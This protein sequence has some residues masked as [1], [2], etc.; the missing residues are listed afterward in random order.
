MKIDN[1]I[2]TIN[3]HHI[4]AET[5]FITEG[6]PPLRGKTMQEKMKYMRENYDHIRKAIMRAPRG[7]RDLFGGVIT[8]PVSDNAH[9]GVFYMG[10]ITDSTYYPMC[11]GGIVALA[12]ML[13]NTGKVTPHEPVTEVVIDTALG[14]VNCKAKV[15]DGKAIEVTFTNVPAFIYTKGLEID[16]NDFGRIKV[17]IGY[18]GGSF[19]VFV[20]M[21]K[22]DFDL[23]RERI[24]DMIDPAIK[25][26]E[27]VNNKIE[28]IHPE[29]DDINRLDS[30]M[31]C[32]YD[33]DKGREL[34]VLGDGLIGRCPSGTGTSARM[35]RE[36]D[37]NKLKM[38][39]E[40]VQKCMIDTSLKGKLV[41]K[42]QVGNIDAYI[43]KITSS[44][45]LT[46]IHEFFIEEDDPLK[47]GYVL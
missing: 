24:N 13:I 22:I 30:C 39:E 1:V 8:E 4:G 29:N 46:G 27:K 45:Y 9:C 43:S 12:T 19:C 42:T 44:A 6:V 16:T 7:S 38:G 14:Q 18:G 5:C 41:K 34:L 31:Y 17:D 10:A 23:K 28:C 37:N 35:I 26:I 15:K 2:R 40:F 25:I 32:D 47:E 20:D 36:Y 3:Y 21:G 33:G 11:G